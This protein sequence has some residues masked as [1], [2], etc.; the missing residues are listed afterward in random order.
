[1]KIH[2][3]LLACV[4]LG[5]G[6]STL[7]APE[8]S[9]SEPKLSV[10]TY[11]VNWGCP[12]PEKVIGYLLEADADV[13]C[14]QETHKR[15]ESLLRRHLGQL[16]PHAYFK[17]AG[18]AGGIAFMSKVQL[19]NVT[20][21]KPTSGWFPAL[22]AEVESPLGAIQILNVHLRPPLSDR[23][24]GT[25]SALYNSPH[26]HRRELA[27]FMKAAD[28]EAPLL[29]VGDFNESERGKAI[30]HLLDNGFTDALSL[31]DRKSDTWF[32]KVLPGITLDN[33]YDHILFNG[34]LACPGAKVSH[35]AASDHMPVCAVLVRNAK[36]A[37]GKD[38]PP[39]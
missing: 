39:R 18:G 35:V 17:D 10:V 23:G 4:S 15:W 13:V 30:Q 16:Y 3:L 34:H 22:L 38:P 8:F 32:W 19:R 21:I 1:M 12:Y 9:P 29:I 11:N 36:K 31:Y 2:S 37:V 5:A 24:S 27:G 6:C 33:R 14:L 7:P 26:I 25:P 28:Q 20:Y